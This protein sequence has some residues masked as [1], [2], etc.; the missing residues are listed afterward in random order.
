MELLK[1]MTEKELIHKIK[2]LN[3]IKP[4]KDWV[5]L[6]KKEILGEEPAFNFFS[7]FNPALAGFALVFFVVFGAFISSRKSLPG[8]FLYNFKKAVEKSQAVFISD[9]NKPAFQLRLA[10]QRLETLGTAPARNL[11]PTLDEFRANI[12][13]AAKNLTKI[14]G[15]TSSPMAIRQIVEETKKLEENKQKAE[16]LGVVIGDEKTSELNDALKKITQNLI[17][18]LDQKTLSEDRIKVLVQMKDLFSQGNYSDALELY[19]I[20][21]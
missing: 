10:N 1:I 2:Q 6:T 18:D 5:L 9:E 20:N 16:S 14:E 8:D 7:Y 15:S 3:Y 17:N 21:Q 12:S 19:L 11:A 4:R 13:E